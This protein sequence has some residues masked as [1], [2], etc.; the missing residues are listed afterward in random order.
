MPSPLLIGD[1]TMIGTELL[2]GQG[3]GN[4]LF[5]YV[6]TRCIAKREQTDFAILNR[7][8]FANNI[9]S[10]KGM[11]FMDLD[12]G[13][14]AEKENF[15]RIYHEKEER[16]YCGNSMHDLTH[17]CYITGC[18][19]TLMEQFDDTLLYGNLQAEEY[20]L[21]YREDIKKWLRVKPEYDC[22]DYARENLCII[23]IRGGEYAGEACLFLRRKYWLDAM[24]AMKKER[25]D[26][27]F[28]VVT[29]D[30]EAARRILPEVKAFHF[31]LAGDYTVIKNAYYLILSN[32]TFAFFPAFTS[33]NL[34]KCIAPKYWARHN[35][36]DG[37]WAS[38]QNI[39]ELFTY[40]DRKG[41]L[42]T[43]KECREELIAYCEKKKLKERIGKQLKG[44]SLTVAKWNVKRLWMQFMAGRAVRSFKRRIFR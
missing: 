31:D 7:E 14:E 33:E 36:S 37:Y 5:C 20:F 35:V 8:I 30:V 13:V 27:E 24:K 42:F 10:N 23:N 19:E 1:L 39:Y 3:L 12:C 22:Q 32:S 9:H 41:R 34:K 2:K 4:Q 18:D 26:M 6:T 25:S 43:A 21:P 38:E 29:D 17:G 15:Q 16:I 11:Y 44:W 40:M 28:M